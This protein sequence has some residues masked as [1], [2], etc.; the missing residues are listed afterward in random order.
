M[1]LCSSDAE[2]EADEDKLDGRLPLRNVKESRTSFFPTKCDSTPI[3]AS[4][5]AC[6]RVHPSSRRT[7]T[8]KGRTGARL[9]PRSRSFRSTFHRTLGHRFH[10]PTS[11]LRIPIPTN[12]PS[13]LPSLVRVY[14]STS[15][16]RGK[17]LRLLWSLLIAA[18][19]HSV[20]HTASFRLQFR[21]ESLLF[22][23]F[24]SLEADRNSIERQTTFHRGRIKS[25]SSDSTVLSRRFWHWLWGTY[26]LRIGRVFQLQA[27]S[28]FV[29]S[30][31]SSSPLS[32]RSD[33]KGTRRT[34]S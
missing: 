21:K 19:S 1:L 12:L 26:R 17:E 32:T 30:R 7:T 5:R 13:L 24:E 34:T 25:V 15:S 8:T 28:F 23:L 9:R 4:F 20:A 14:S 22:S 11:I 3:Q 31:S 10:L 2:A 27:S 33:S 18:K 16:P 29:W 6:R